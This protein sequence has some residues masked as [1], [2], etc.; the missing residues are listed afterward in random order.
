MSWKKYLNPVHA[1]EHGVEKLNDWFGSDPGGP[2]GVPNDQG[3][4]DIL[5]FSTD[6]MT[7]PENQKIQTTSYMENGGSDMFGSNTAY[8][9][10]KEQGSWWDRNQS[11]LIPTLTTL[12][13]TAAGMIYNNHQ[14]NKTNEFNANE[15]QKSRDFNLYMSN[16]AH[17]REME[18]LVAA[19]LNPANTANGGQGAGGESGAQASG[20][21]PQYMGY[22]DMAN[23]ALSLAE[24]M[25]ALTENKYISKEK[26][27]QIANTIADTTNKEAQTSET[28]ANE[29][30]IKEQTKQIKIDNITREDMNRIEMALKQNQSKETLENAIAKAMENAYHTETGTIPNMTTIERA[31]NIATNI[32]YENIKNGKAPDPISAIQRAAKEIKGSK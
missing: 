29:N 32:I 18:D 25:K 31:A 14:Q 11:W 26:K 12:G 30:L 4:G 17:Q 7:G 20:A 22:G 13:T 3:S 27:A 2:T 23:T 15:A 5:S 24:T 8:N 16:T 19:G 9:E 6:T 10:E 1:I 21:N 28:K